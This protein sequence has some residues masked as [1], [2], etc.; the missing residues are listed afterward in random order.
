MRTFL[1][2]SNQIDS[3]KNNQAYELVEQYRKR[4][5]RG[6]TEALKMKIVS[7][8]GTGKRN[9]LVEFVVNDRG[10]PVRRG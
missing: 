10:R 7:D 6:F 8:V 2:T 9:E 1:I 4:T 5:Q 3:I